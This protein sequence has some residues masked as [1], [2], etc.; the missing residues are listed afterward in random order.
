MAVALIRNKYLAVNIGPEG[1]GIYGILAS[2]FSMIAVFAGTWMATGTMKYVSEYDAKGEQ[3]SVNTVFTFSVLLTAGIAFVLTLVLICKRKWF[4]AHFLSDDVLEVYY[5]IFAVSFIAMN[6]RPILI[7]VLQGQKKIREVVI[8]RWGIALIDIIFV[9][10]LVRFWGLTG[11]FASILLNSTFA[12]GFLYWVQRKNGAQ[13]CKFAWR[14]PRVYLLM[15]FGAV[16]FFLAFINLGSQYLQRVIVIQNMDI[17]AVGILQAGVGL[18]RHLG[19]IN[20]GAQFFYFPKM[21]EN[22]T[23]DIR[24]KN[25]NNYLRFTLIVGIPISV[26]ALLFGKLIIV[27]LYSSQFVSLAPIFFLF[28]IG[29]F[30]SSI[31]GAFQ[32]AIV[33]AAWLKMHTLSSIVIHSLV[34]IMPFLLINKYGVGAVGIGFVVAGLSGAFMNWLYLR[35]KIGLRFNRQVVQL[36]IIAVIT[37][38]GAILLCDRMLMWR[39]AWVIMSIY[40][41]GKMVRSE[42][43][44]K[45]YNYILVKLGKRKT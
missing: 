27:I 3:R 20:R 15:H 40:L 30:I 22:M 4:I 19:V 23:R 32:S 11:F 25:I 42:E 35:H 5:L 28:V 8:S 33:G 37:L 17:A 9:I 18:M 43:W 26:L 1:F 36:L 14:D 45:G 12:V 29:Q 7:A 34:V 6:L 16:N 21:S 44:E 24:N 31:G 39:I 38:S 13:F 41:I 10:I 2:F